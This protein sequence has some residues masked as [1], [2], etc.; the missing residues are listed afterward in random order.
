MRRTPLPLL[1]T[2]LIALVAAA[3]GN[4]ET[5]ATAAGGDQPDG[6]VVEVIAAFYPLAEAAE[7]V[8]GDR[9]QVRNL[10]PPGVEAHDL[11]LSPADIDAIE[12]ADVVI[13]MGRGFQPSVERAAERRE[14]PTL[15][16]LRGLPI[17]QE[18]DVAEHTH[19]D[20][21]DD[22]G[23]G[24]EGDDHGHDDEGDDHGHSHDD[25]GDD[26]GHDDEGGR[27]GALD[28]HVWLDP[29]L[30]AATIDLVVE[31]LSE[32]DPDGAEVYEA[33]GAAYRDEVE[34][35]DDR[36]AEGLADCRLD[37]VVVSHEA[38]GWMAE[39]YGFDQEGIRGLSPEA[40]PDPRRMA[41]LADLV[42]ERGVE[43]IFTEPF[44]S[45]RVAETLARETGA[46]VRTL[47]PLEG[48]TAPELDAGD[49]YVSLMEQN[50][51]ELREAMDCR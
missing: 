27:E 12:D 10:T 24:D 50:L 9:V 35:L 34:G 6:P 17:D 48:L 2:A 3:C 32:A 18:G 1:L 49:D 42:S 25:E 33:N 8:G 36:F 11:E 45:P 22:H 37:L 14:G 30:M 39:R 13:V 43:V 7:R 44:V 29:T 4:G 28:P 15:E 31:A 38:F 5:D 51:E 40:E 19:G 26:H 47:H 16:V 23:H 46:A 20:E 41:E 21:G